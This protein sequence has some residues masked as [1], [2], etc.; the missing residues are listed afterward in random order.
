MSSWRKECVT[1]CHLITYVV[2]Q[3]NFERTFHTYSIKVIVLLLGIIIFTSFQTDGIVLQSWHSWVLQ[4]ALQALIDSTSSKPKIYYVHMYIYTTGI[5]AL[6]AQLDVHPTGDQEVV[7]STPA[8]VGNILS[9]RLI[10]KY[11]LRSFSRFRWRSCQFLAK[12]CAQYWLT[13]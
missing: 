3:P 6:V 7:G 9:W 12:E 13:A 2:R 8:K 11:F 4:T 1:E 5:S 10:I